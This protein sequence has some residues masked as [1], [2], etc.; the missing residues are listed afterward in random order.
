MKVSFIS[1]VIPTFNDWHRLGLCLDALCAQTYPNAYFEVIVVNNDPADECPHWFKPYENVIILNE[2]KPGSYAARNRALEV[3]KGEIIGFT[4]SDT[5]PDPKWIE[6]AVAYFWTNESVYRIAG[7]INLFYQTSRPTA[8]ELYD[9]L[10]AFRQKQYVEELGF[11]VTANMFTYKHLFD[12]IGPFNA[13]LLSGGDYEWG[14]RANNSGYPIHFVDSVIVLHPAR[15]KYNELKRK[16]KRVSG[17]HL[18]MKADA[19]SRAK[20]MFNFLRGL[21]PKVEDINY[22]FK[23]N[24]ITL[25]EKIMVFGIRHHLNILSNLEKVKISFGNKLE[26]R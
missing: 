15:S 20:L 14:R 19:T 11:G 5:I 3:A 4:D 24:K 9:A 12:D 6:N 21:K 16:I 13:T 22:I 1:I 2:V 17:G 25:A 7:A 10:F 8:V 18:S 23:S 26:R